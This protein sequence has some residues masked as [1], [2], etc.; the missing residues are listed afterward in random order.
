LAGFH[1]DFRGQESDVSYREQKSIQMYTISLFVP[2][3]FDLTLVKEYA[4]M[5]DGGGASALVHTLQV[6][7]DPW[8]KQRRTE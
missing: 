4:I 5:M 7:L 8:L 2:G 6:Q 1:P 3:R